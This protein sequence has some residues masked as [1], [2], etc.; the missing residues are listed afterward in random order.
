MSSL[1]EALPSQAIGLHQ[2]LFW[3][4]TSK[5]PRGCL[6]ADRD[7]RYWSG[8]CWTWIT[9]SGLEYIH[10]FFGD[11]RETCA[12]KF[13]LSNQVPFSTH[14][15]PRQ[16]THF[17]RAR[18][19]NPGDLSLF[20]LRDLQSILESGKSHSQGTLTEGEMKATPRHVSFCH[21]VVSLWAPWAASALGKI[22][23]EKHYNS[24]GTLLP[25]FCD[26]ILSALCHRYHKLIKSFHAWPL[27]T[28]LS[29]KRGLLIT[30]HFWQ[31]P[32]GSAAFCSSERTPPLT[33]WMLNIDSYYECCQTPSAGLQIRSGRSSGRALANVRSGIKGLLDSLGMR[34]IDSIKRE[35][36]QVLVM[37]EMV[38]AEWGWACSDVDL[39]TEA[40]HKWPRKKMLE[41]GRPGTRAVAALG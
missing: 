11:Q 35:T 9:L 14:R 10:T 16:P 25:K 1:A 15:T 31:L 28:M 3:L 12:P 37:M 39:R 30:T 41:V 20:T 33:C 32:R 8:G 5:A 27:L 38:V 40:A 18:Q 34:F 2:I 19:A 4:L 29:E 24:P 6:K 21:C 17:C 26:Y 36:D 7:H 23:W 22:K 13:L